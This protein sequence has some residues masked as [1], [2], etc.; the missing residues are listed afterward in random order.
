MYLPTL[1]ELLL[2]GAKEGP[3]PVTTVELA[4]RIGKSQQAASKH[5]EALEDAG[6][7]ERFKKGRKV[8]VRI[9]S[10]GV[11]EL[12]GLYLVL[13]SILEEAPEA[14]VFSGRVFS[15]LGEGRYYMSL[16]GYR[17]QFAKKLGFK[18][19]PGTMNIRLESP[20]QVIQFRELAGKEGISIEGFTD[21]LRTFGDV[22]CFR[23]LIEHISG[24]VLIIERTHYDYSVMELIAPVNI[25][26]ELGLR[27][28][29]KIVVKVFHRGTVG[30]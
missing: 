2:M 6:L 9:T 30:V 29:D 12:I 17:G 16:E 14:Y 10:R 28:G 25:R 8:E 3:V 15:G 27:D 23:A 5:M 18:P 7:I 11:N 19:Y 20:S 13:R 4:R 21:G 26:E 1:I 22:K 24:A